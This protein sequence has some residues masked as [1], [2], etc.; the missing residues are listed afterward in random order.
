[1]SPVSSPIPHVAKDTGLQNLSPRG[2]LAASHVLLPAAE[3][4][5]GQLY[6]TVCKGA[7]LYTKELPLPFQGLAG[8]GLSFS[9]SGFRFEASLF[10]CS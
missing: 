5:A 2:L 4:V 10:P 8:F 9:C 6:D 3:E 1:M 7:V